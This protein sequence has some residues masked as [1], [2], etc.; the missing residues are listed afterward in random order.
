MTLDLTD[1]ARALEALRRA[2]ETS[3]NLPETASADLRETVQAGVVHRFEVAF[4]LCWKTAQQWLRENGPSGEGDFPR[5][6]QE[7]FRAAAEYGLLQDPAA[8][9]AFGEARNRA[10]H[11]CDRETAFD[12]FSVARAFLPYGMELFSAIALRND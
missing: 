2:V 5:T 9:S 8:W 10:P 4:G 6:R 12:V 7:L 1:L 3:R 11:A